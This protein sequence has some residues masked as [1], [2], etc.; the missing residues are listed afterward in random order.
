[1]A[2][3]SHELQPGIF[4]VREVPTSSLQVFQVLNK[5]ANILRMTINIAGS[6]GTKIEGVE[7]D[8]VTVDIPPMDNHLLAKLIVTPTARVRHKF[9]FTLHDPP[10]DSVVGRELQGLEQ[11]LVLWAKASQH[12]LQSRD[13]NTCPE[14]V[15]RETPCQHFVDPYFVPGPRSVTHGEERRMV[16]WRRPSE[17]FKG[18]YKVFLD[19]IEP[20]DI[21]QGLLG[22]CWLMC[23]LASLAER[24]QLVKR[25]FVTTQVTPYGIYRIRL[26][27]NGE[28]QTVSVDDYFPCAPFDTP[29]FSRSH[30]NE[31]WVLLVEKAYA[32]LHGNYLLLKGGWAR[33][34]MLDLTGCPTL[35]YDFQSEEVKELVEE[36]LLWPLLRQ[37]DQEAALISASTPGEDRWSESR[38]QDRKG[39]LIGGHAY[40]V[41]QVR[42]AY[43]QRLL[44]IRNPW[45]NFEW[46]GAWSDKSP[47]WTDRMKSALKPVL[48]ENDGT[49]WMN[50]EDFLKNFQSVTVCLVKP[51]FEARCKGVFE[52]ISEESRF[53]TYSR[54]YSVLTTTER[55]RVYIGIHQED[56][57]ILGVVSKRPNLD[58]GLM[59][60]E[61]TPAGLRY[62]KRKE[63]TNDRQ[64]ELEIELRPD[65][66]YLLLPCS[67]GCR[68]Q[69]GKEGPMESLTAENFL[70]RSTLLDIFHKA[71]YEM[72]GY[73]SYAELR[74]LLQETGLDFDEN[75]YQLCLQAYSSTPQGLTREGFVEMM[76]AQTAEAGEERVRRW[77][78][79]WGYGKDLF[80]SKSRT[81]VIS[82]HCE[83]DCVE[84]KTEQLGTRELDHKAS[85]IELQQFGQVKTTVRNV[86]I[87]QMQDKGSMAYTYGAHNANTAGVRVTID[88][89]GSEGVLFSTGKPQVTVSIAPGAWEILLT[90]LPDA[91]APRCSIRSA[92]SVSTS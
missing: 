63:R 8:S 52:R 65:R 90:V 21:K 84:L 29:I 73:M 66:R 51:F 91:N 14:V 41:I 62:F 7:G 19:S 60:L 34:G 75:R 70:Y 56:E 37:F 82:V 81:Y 53:Y 61:Q 17:F 67:S 30:G 83:K 40:S 13:I 9:S 27:K 44:N 54:S 49:F 46:D 36:D 87:Y 18:E 6:E 47:L 20:N 1:M 15:F 31:L 11:N 32:K 35:G 38:G 45:G 79:G 55:A 86:E 2:S 12:A 33:E 78:Q 23:A 48:E 92:Y 5:K 16:H 50:Y 28:W 3:V 72:T 22:D 26:C 25:L 39:G 71:T 85:L 68:M 89:T 57:R 74:D 76:I 64:I 77:L 10:T 24:P 80:S 42:E 4:L 59:I 88:C 69:Q 58:L 43:S